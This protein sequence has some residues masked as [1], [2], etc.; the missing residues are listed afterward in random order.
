MCCSRGT[1]R[2]GT[3]TQDILLVR[4]NIQSAQGS[5]AGPMS[6]PDIVCVLPVYAPVADAGAH[7]TNLTQHIPCVLR[8]A[9]TAI[10]IRK[11]RPWRLWRRPAGGQQVGLSK[12]APA[13]AG[14]AA[15]QQERWA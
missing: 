9:K 6:G 8:R 14:P 1:R 5:T 3:E 13:Q 4:A 11:L 15:R 7:T 12:G 10:S 2:N